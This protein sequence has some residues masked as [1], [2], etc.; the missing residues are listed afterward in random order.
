MPT[1]CSASAPRPR[2]ISPTRPSHHDAEDEHDHDDFDS[3]VVDL[4]ASPTPPRCSTR[5][6][7]VA[8]RA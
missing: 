6:P 4:P 3:F 7:T 1:C 2:T 8:E 5:S